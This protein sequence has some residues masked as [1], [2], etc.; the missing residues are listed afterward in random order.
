MIEVFVKD[1]DKENVIFLASRVSIIENE[2]A[3]DDVIIGM[4]VEAQVKVT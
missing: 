1:V 3:I 4:L 2:D